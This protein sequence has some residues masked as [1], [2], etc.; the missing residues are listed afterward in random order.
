MATRHHDR[1]NHRN[2]LRILCW[3]AV[4]A[5]LWISG[6]FVSGYARGFAWVAALG[7]EIGGPWI[8]YFVPGL[9]RSQ[10][11]DWK[12][13]GG[14]MAERCSLF[15]I[16]ALGEG[17]VVTGRTF[18]DHAMTGDNVAAF[19]IAFVGSVL[20]WWI[21]FDLGAK[22]GAE[23]I[24]HLAEPGRV[25]RNAYTYLHMPIVAGIILAAVGDEL[26]LAHPDGHAEPRLVAFQC[27]SLAIYLLGV[28]SFKR[29][30]SPIGKFPLS[31]LAGLCLLAP[32][33]LWA[34]LVHVPALLFGVLTLAVLTEQY[35]KEVLLVGCQ[36][37]EIDD[38]GGSLRP[39][40]KQAMEDA[41]A[42]GI[43]A[44][45]RWGARPVARQRPLSEVETVTFSE[46]SLGCYE[47]QRPPE[48]IAC[49]LG[50]ER[51][52]PVADPA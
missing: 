21:Y 26:L 39:V 15:I 5:V 50:D 27:G 20:M 19:L 14:H 29:T 2:F 33:A 8:G 32:L 13:D 24:E 6:G 44:L 17:V 40:V 28:G 4:S 23:L 30:A 46:L 3:L 22:R 49:R 47:S 37:E 25:A 43:D 48:E 1:V 38:Y 36:P 35:P 45:R 18:A 41:L 34:W 51:F 9:G 52:F 10:T 7:L 11:A 31:H 16:I 42:L 12:V